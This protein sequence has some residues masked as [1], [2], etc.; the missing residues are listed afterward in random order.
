MRLEN[1]NKIKFRASSMWKLMTDPRSKKEELSETCITH[2]VDLFV[3]YKYDRREFVTSKYLEKGNEREE[4]AIGLLSFLTQIEY[5]KNTERLQNEF[6]QGEPD[7]YNGES[8]FN[9]K[10]TL[11]TKVSWS[12]N[13]FFRTK[14]KAVD[15]EYYW[16]GQTYMD[17]TGSD[18]HSVVF[19]LVNGTAKAIM[20]EKRLAGYQ[21]GII[22][23]GATKNEEYKERCKQIEINH[24]VDLASFQEEYG[25]FDFDND[26]SNWQWDI[27]YE[28]RMFQ[29]HFERNQED[30]DKMHDRVKKCRK[31]MNKN[32]F[33]IGDLNYSDMI[34]KGNALRELLKNRI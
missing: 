32:L 29:F 7:L 33:K 9:A 1:A 4:Q 14:N 16:Q 25:F 18:F 27:P 12:V 13:T 3:Q 8:I 22:D 10:R 17:L 19:C 24:I 30:I 34:K 20:D 2:L 15:K 6:T 5:I 28:D 26:V 21:Y 23:S 31:W 11:D